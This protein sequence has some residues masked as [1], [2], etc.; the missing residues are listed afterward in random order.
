MKEGQFSGNVSPFSWFWDPLKF[1]QNAVGENSTFQKRRNI[2][3]G[4]I[5]AQH[6]CRNCCLLLG[7]FCFVAKW[8]M[9]PSRQL[10]CYNMLTLS[11]ITVFLKTPSSFRTSVVICQHVAAQIGKQ[12]D[13][14]PYDSLINV[15]ILLLYRSEKWANQWQLQPSSANK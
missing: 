5:K 14:F 12:R 10:F 2:G 13:I 7:F 8:V 1:V 6:Q 3:Y 9:L 4:G 11:C 15:K